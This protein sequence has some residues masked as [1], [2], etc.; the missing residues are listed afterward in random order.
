MF[1]VLAPAFC[2][3]QQDSVLQVDEMYVSFRQADTSASGLVN[4]LDTRQIQ[5]LQADDVGELIR[6][7]SGVNLRAYGGLGGL[8]TISVRSLG[9]QHTVVNLDGFTLLSTQ[10]GQVN[11][12]Q[13]QAVNLESVALANSPEENRNLPVSALV[14]GNALVLQSFENSWGREGISLR[15]NAGIGSFGHGEGFLALKFRHKS[16]QVGASGSMRGANGNYPYRFEN[17]YQTVSGYRTNNRYQ[18]ATG[19]ISLLRKGRKSFFRIGYRHKIISQELPGAVILYG[20]VADE[21]LNTEEGS[22]FA[23]G[24]WKWKMSVIRLY[25]QGVGQKLR[26]QDPGYLNASGGLDVE[27]TNRTLNGGINIRTAWKKWVFTAGTEE[28]VS[29]LQVNDS[30][31]AA[32]LRLHNMSLLGARLQLS[33]IECTVQISSQYVS[34][35]NANGQNA[36][37]RFRVNPYAACVVYARNRRWMQTI[38][39]RNSFRMPSFNE[40]YY[41]SVGNVHLEPE[42]AHQFNYGLSWL[43]WNR[44]MRLEFRTNGFM[45][46]VKNKI[47]A[48]P[49]QNLFVWSMQ[50]VG[51]TRIYGGEASLDASWKWGKKW[52]AGLALNYTFQ[53]ALDYSDPASPTYKDQLA[54]TPVHSGNADLTLSFGKTGLLISNYA[55]AMRY[56]LNEN[57]PQN[58]VPGFW[59]TDIGVYHTFAFRKDQLLTLRGTVKN[60]FNQSYAF[61]R[62]YVMPGTNYLITLSYAIH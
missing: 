8:K 3:G 51:Q 45:N 23:D 54:Y 36:G 17:G 6:K 41:N 5:A 34:E 1:I 38:W 16:W 59:I 58:E 56:M 12:A 29:D 35:R 25:A 15:A 42:D 7:F 55:V 19:N 62:S 57:V 37:D 40:L 14:A 32:P 24:E 39:Y 21:R 26:Y 13:L 61:I 43:A 60:V 20:G 2:W 53:R 18:D 28:F 31:F 10:T 46:L 52:K 4:Q 11:L 9:A 49:T 44:K 33:R 47:V 22:L 30:L 27:Y 50:N 48:I